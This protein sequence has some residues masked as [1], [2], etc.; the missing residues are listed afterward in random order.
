[1]NINP[2]E[3]TILVIDDS[4]VDGGVYSGYILSR[5]S[6]QEPRRSVSGLADALALCQEYS[7][8]LILLNFWRD[9]GNLL[10]RGCLKRVGLGNKSYP[11]RSIDPSNTY[12]LVGDSR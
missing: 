4:L 11:I 8:D 2:Q 12:F 10:F 7:P 9:R 1:M 3:L 5:H 6:P